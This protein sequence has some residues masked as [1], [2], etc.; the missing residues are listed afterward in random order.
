MIGPSTKFHGPPNRR[1]PQTDWE[2]FDHGSQT[3]LIV[4][5]EKNRGFVRQYASVNGRTFECCYCMEKT[6]KSVIA[7][8]TKNAEG[9]YV[10]IAAVDHIHSPECPP[11][12][13]KFCV[14]FN[15][16]EG[17]VSNKQKGINMKVKKTAMKAAQLGSIQS[18]IENLT[19]PKPTLEFQEKID[20]LNGNFPTTSAVKPKVKIFSIN[21][22]SC[23]IIPDEDW[24]YGIG[25]RGEPKG[26]IIVKAKKDI[27]RE[28]RL[29]KSSQDGKMREYYCTAC[30]HKYGRT[31]KVYIETSASGKETA[32]VLIAK[33]HAELCKGIS[34]NE[35][36]EKQRAVEHRFA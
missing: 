5:E 36:Y 16:S 32:K 26:V 4:R 30:Q 2:L 17:V 25:I 31:I 1:I 7:T 11:I 15:Q 6:G 28:F 24:E 13:Y 29:L 21:P 12:P 3:Y 9:R 34:L 33:P 8:A 27:V 19:V 23:R 35:A 18:I 10:V 22:S 20:I 14:K